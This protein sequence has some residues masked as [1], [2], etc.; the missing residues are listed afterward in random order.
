MKKIKIIKRLIYGL[1]SAVILTGMTTLPC[2]AASGALNFAD[3]CG[4]SDFLISQNVPLTNSYYKRY[5]YG[6]ETI[7][8]LRDDLLPSYN[9]DGSVNPGGNMTGGFT[10]Y[11]IDVTKNQGKY[12]IERYINP[13]QHEYDYTMPTGSILPVG[14][15]ATFGDMAHLGDPTGN[16]AN[17]PCCHCEGYR[18]TDFLCGR[19]TS[20][21]GTVFHSVQGNLASANETVSPCLAVADRWV[22]SCAVCGQ[23]LNGCDFLCS[24]D[25]LVGLDYLCIG[26]ETINLCLECGGME[27]TGHINHV[28][29]AV[30]NNRYHINF[31]IGTNDPDAYGSQNSLTWYHSYNISDGS[32]EYEKQTVKGATTLPSTTTFVRPGYKFAGW[33]YTKGGSKIPYYSLK[34][35]EED[36]NYP[37]NDTTITVYALW[38]A[39]ESTVTINANT[40]NK[41]GNNTAT[42]KGSS[43]YT[44]RN[45]FHTGRTKGQIDTLNQF[46]KNS[47]TINASD[48]VLPVGYTLTFNTNGG[49]AKDY[50]SK[51][52]ISKLSAP[53]YCIG[54][55]QNGTSSV[56][57]STV[58]FSNHGVANATYDTSGHL[59]KIAYTYMGAPYTDTI[60]LQYEQ[61]SLKLPSCEKSGALFVGWYSSSSFANGTYIGTT[62]DYYMPISNMTLYARFSEMNIEATD[63]YYTTSSTPTYSTIAR[64]SDGQANNAYSTP[65]S[66]LAFNYAKGAIAIRNKMFVG[67]GSHITYETYYKQ[68]GTSAWTKVDGN[69][70][71]EGS[72]A[73]AYNAT[74][75]NPGTYSYTVQSTGYYT[76]D[77]YGAQGDNYD[78]TYTGG[79]GG[80]A[81][82][83]VYLYEG[84]V[85]TVEI[86]AMSGLGTNSKGGSN[87]SNGPYYTGRSGGGATTVSVTHNGTKTILLVAGGGGAAGSLGNGGAGGLTTSLMST[88]NGGNGA[89]AGGGGYQG[90]RAGNYLIHTHGSNTGGAGSNTGYT[91]DAN[92]NAVRYTAIDTTTVACY[93]RHYT[94]SHS[95]RCG[96]SVI[97]N[98]GPWTNP[99]S[100]DCAAGGTLHKVTIYVPD[101]INYQC[102]SWRK[103]YC[104]SSWSWTCSAC[105]LGVDHSMPNPGSCDN[106]ITVDG[107]DYY[108]IDSCPYG[109]NNENTNNFIISSYG[110][111][112]GSNYVNTSVDCY[113]SANL[114]GKRS[115]NGYVSIT[116]TMVGLRDGKD[117]EAFDILYV[118]DSTR[119][120]AVN[121][122]ID[123]TN[124]TLTLIVDNNPDSGA[125][126]YDVYTKLYNVTASGPQFI[127]DSSVLTI[128][129]K[130]AVAGYY[131]CFDNSASTNISTS[132]SPYTY[133]N[134]HSSAYSFATGKSIPVTNT[135]AGYAHIAAVDVAG[136]IGPTTHLQLG[137]KQV[138][139]VTFVRN[140]LQN[141]ITEPTLNGGLS[142][143]SVY[144]A[145][146]GTN[147]TNNNKGVYGSSTNLTFNNFP[148]V[149]ANGSVFDGWNTMPDGSGTWVT[150][151]T[152]FIPTDGMNIYAVYHETANISGTI[153]YK[154]AKNNSTTGVEVI[155][156]IPFAFNDETDATL[157]MTGTTTPWTKEAK[158]TYS[159]TANAT[160]VSY[161]NESVTGTNT[162]TTKAYADASSKTFTRN[163]V[164]NQI[165]GTNNVTLYKNKTFTFTEN[166]DI[167][168]IYNINTSV[169]TRQGNGAAF[170]QN[171]SNAKVRI[172]KTVPYIEHFSVNRETINPHEDILSQIGK[173]FKTTF[174]ITVSDYMLKADG[175]PDSTKKDTAGIYG[176]YISVIDAHNDTVEKVYK[177]KQTP[178]DYTSEGNV[179]KGT[180]TFSVDLAS[181]F[182]D[183]TKLMYHIYVVDNAGNTSDILDDAYVTDASGN[184]ITD[185]NG[186]PVISF[187][188]GDTSGITGTKQVTGY[189]ESGTIATLIIN[190]GS[191]DEDNRNAYNNLG[192]LT[193]FKAGDFGHIE[194]YAVGYVESITWDFGDVGRESQKEIEDGLIESK[195]NLQY[196]GTSSDLRTIS[197]TKGEILYP[198]KFT[199]TNDDGSERTVTKTGN[200]TEYNNIL[201]NDKGIPYA[202]KYTVTVPTKGYSDKWGNDGTSIR[203]PPYY[204][205]E[206]I[207]DEHGNPTGEEAWETH[208]YG[209]FGK[210]GD[211]DTYTAQGTYVI[212]GNRNDDVHER[213]TKFYNTQ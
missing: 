197:Y 58:D 4:V 125:T 62:G 84:D 173:G 71:Q 87:T 198:D 19:W 86:G 24:A 164:D 79:L 171:K 205:L 28:C 122:H 111:Y 50:T 213:V 123:A 93:S 137:L 89:A 53:V 8:R 212:Y 68:T 181:N 72:K 154:K 51:A 56:S 203:I 191:P 91:Y 16:G 124:N 177:M 110:G 55:S 63:A 38:Q 26:D 40:N 94:E 7:L 105:H 186:N 96:A 208:N 39:E 194:V 43:A 102:T 170:N 144:L 114:S 1:L 10:N 33:S 175:T 97:A 6:S 158:V 52:V 193:Y 136:N 143:V 200:P 80:E 99:D 70:A 81:K 88:G 179:I 83:T 85:V 126:K 37:V 159:T 131:Y 21:K 204:K 49:T 187:P 74:Y 196:V 192:G 129:V 211:G 146:D 75:S 185:E 106:Y 73:T 66:S 147:V 182:P 169:F 11:K 115:G 108:A 101:F 3:E 119:P 190:E 30:S 57:T 199:I 188:T 69:M 178:L 140:P 41:W 167:E 44:V 163:T 118:T 113:N 2:S 78:T 48:I 162:F 112:G 135:S 47:F 60:T 174:T 100:H 207:L 209:V 31:D 45:T 151:S 5:T 156:G 180:Y 148:T 77:A 165:V 12:A 92:G 176:A 202:V 166:L 20:Y 130:S 117:N 54:F 15:W 168:G 35:I 128:G 189:V 155:H 67:S 142:N 141:M 46:T 32:A 90:G 201:I 76:L 195:Y 107:E 134:N 23:R 206:D 153:T 120:E 152:K 65:S 14:T 172:D 13:G 210:T 184:P 95:E 98:V 157:A 61:G 59:S 82:N 42:V 27:A 183:C 133:S 18:V 150:T 127:Q 36:K 132:C 160:G 145:K 64:T 161:I 9:S 149:N 138:V 22:A 121:A 139:K 103:H 116:A 17:Y 29:K 25:Y 34:Q 104:G 109:L